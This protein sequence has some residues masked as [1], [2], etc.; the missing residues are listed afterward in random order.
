[1]FKRR[2]WRLFNRD[3]GHSSSDDS[4][5]DVDNDGRGAL[6]K[7]GADGSGS[8]SEGTSSGDTSGDESNSDG[9]KK[10]HKGNDSGDDDS[11]SDGDASDESND[12]SE[13]T[14]TAL[15]HKIDDPMEDPAPKKQTD[16]SKG[17]AV[18]CS[19]CPGVLCLSEKSLQQHLDSKKHK[20]AM[21]TQ[22]VGIDDEDVLV[23]AAAAGR[24]ALA[25]EA[26]NR[27]ANGDDSDS[28]EAYSDGEAETHAERSQRLRAQK[29][30]ARDAPVFDSDDE[31]GD[32]A[33]GGKMKPGGRQR[34]RKR[35]RKGDEK[36]GEKGDK[37]GEKKGVEKADKKGGEKADKKGAKTADAKASE[38]TAKPEKK[39][40]P[41]K[42]QRE[43]QKALMAAEAAK[44][45]STWV[46][47]NT[48]KREAAA[49]AAGG[50]DAADTGDDE[51]R[52]P[53]DTRPRKSRAKRAGEAAAATSALPV[54]RGAY[55]FSAEDLN[56]KAPGAEKTKGDLKMM[57]SGGGRGGGR[58][59]A[60]R[61]GVGQPRQTDQPGAVVLQGREG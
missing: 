55:D 51:Y 6:D 14:P 9:E 43:A 50:G 61:G 46:P 38:L 21:S 23:D 45:A 13:E 57:R 7:L 8:G 30:L 52:A 25:R 11:D 47:R 40:K 32:A 24:K 48:K 17:I 1:M 22:G 60:V 27:A 16:P 42:R 56:V 53:G 5:S 49:G 44:T 33:K 18:K 37:D 31:D 10:E 59:H 54:K 20:K 12:E 28:L 34:Q 58:G 15:T 26:A 41:G 36:G 2:D 19:V 39:G 3:D 29:V 4:D 35:A